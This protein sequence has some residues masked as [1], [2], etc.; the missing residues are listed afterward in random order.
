ME[1]SDHYPLEKVNERISYYKQ[2][3]ASLKKEELRTINQNILRFWENYKSNYYP[4][5]KAES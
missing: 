1:K 3:L 4:D 5:E 2:L